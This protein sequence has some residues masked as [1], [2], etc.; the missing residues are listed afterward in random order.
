M[1]AIT[2][3]VAVAVSAEVVSV[4][5]ARAKPAVL[6]ILGDVRPPVFFDTTRCRVDKS[7]NLSLVGVARLH[8]VVGDWLVPAPVFVSRAVGSGD[9]YWGASSGIWV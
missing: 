1:I 4:K 6:G 2:V 9:D 3:P 5:I 8:F 7:G